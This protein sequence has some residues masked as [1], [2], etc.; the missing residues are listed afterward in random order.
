MQNLHKDGANLQY[1][2]WIYASG[3][4]IR[5]ISG[6]NAANTANVGYEF[7]IRSDVNAAQLRLRVTAGGAVTALGS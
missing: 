4:G 3:T 6:T 2:A 7:S 1:L 5:A